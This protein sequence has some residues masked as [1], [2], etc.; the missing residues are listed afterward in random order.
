VN[1][2]AEIGRYLSDVA[3]FRNCIPVAG[4]LDHVGEDGTPTTL[5]LLQ[6]FVEN[7]GDGFAFSVNYL[8]QFLE[9]RTATADAVVTDDP[10]G[11]Y[12]ALVRTLGTRTAELHIALGKAASD[13]AFR[14]EP[15][16]QVDVA[17]W[18][19]RAREQAMH[20]LD[21]LAQRLA[22]L[23]AGVRADAEQVLTRRN[24]IASRLA[25]CS[26][27]VGKPLIRIHGDYHLGQ[28]LLVQNDF[29][30]TDFEGEPARPLAERRRKQSPLKDV[31]GMLRSFDY[32]M[33]SAVRR[34]SADRPDLVPALLPLAQRWQS[35]AVRAYLEAYRAT[36]S[37][38]ALLP[39]EPAVQAVL[40]FFVMEKA[41]YELAYELDNR[42]DWVAI[43]LRGI[44]SAVQTA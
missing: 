35:E 21:R 32:A 42:P 33:H 15:A 30:I 24:A 18:C 28:V 12:L 43:P 20:T 2:D 14:P 44:A 6:G 8:A 38:S 3:Q 31:A 4:T 13:P 41:L 37:L 16:T 5:V 23:P 29:V 27:A 25:D 26:G 36:M 7:Q 9:A 34:V 40:D 19:A 10:H 17:A 11:G 1:P 39:D 22:A